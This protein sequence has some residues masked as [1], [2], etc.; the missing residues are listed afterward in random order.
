MQK[1]IQEEAMSRV[2]QAIKVAIS[3]GI[4]KSEDEMIEEYE[5]AADVEAIKIIEDTNISHEEKKRIQQVIVN[6]HNK[7]ID[8][9]QKEREEKQTSKKT[10]QEANKEENIIKTETNKEESIIKPEVIIQNDKLSNVTSN[11]NSSEDTI[12]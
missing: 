7:G 11:V 12:V 2:E 6:Q 3:S 1:Q 5:N 8:E 10:P 4:I 9:R